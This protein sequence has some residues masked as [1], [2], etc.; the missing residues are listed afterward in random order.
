MNVGQLEVTDLELV[1]YQRGKPAIRW[2]LK[3]LRRYGYDSEHFSFESGRRSPTGPG[4]YAFL[5][6]RA[7]QLVALLETRL[8]VLFPIMIFIFAYFIF[9]QVR[10][11]TENDCEG[12]RRI[13]H[14][15]SSVSSGGPLSPLS[16]TTPLIENLPPVPAARSVS[17][18]LY[19][20]DETAA[21]LAPPPATAPTERQDETNNNKVGENGP[22]HTYTNTLLGG[23]DPEELTPGH[24]YMNI[25]PGTDNKV[26]DYPIQPQPPQ[27]VP[28]E[29]DDGPHNY[30]N[31]DV[32]A[33]LEAIVRPTAPPAL[34]PTLNYIVLD[35]EPGS[36]PPPPPRL[37][38][39]TPLP[40]D[41][42]KKPPGGY[43]TIDFD[44]TTALS[45]SVDPTFDDDE[46][47]RKTRHNSHI[48]QLPRHS[49][50]VSD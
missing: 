16:S 41:S 18:N 45:H 27:F 33:A 8:Q 30:A 12:N 10:P 44:K 14:R 42:P 34:Q 20:N 24:L 46:C 9:I 47:S 22:E 50:S 49:S 4:I 25:V 26:P 11:H 35:L 7:E 38:P 48:S 31:L 40:P 13:S 28:W 19:A 39:T 37:S 21:I 2:P 3:T 15:L 17:Q 32:D 43:A 36:E 6:R 23:P 29:Q 5:C 1:F